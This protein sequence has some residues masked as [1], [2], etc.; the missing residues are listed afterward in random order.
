M[1]IIAAFDI[2][3]RRIGVAFSDPFASYAMP[4]ETYFRTGNFRED[5]EQIV[6]IAKERGATVIVCGLPLNADGTESV[7]S[8]KTRRFAAALEE[9]AGVPVVLEDER[10]TTREARGDL[11]LLGISTKKDKKK[12]SVDSLAAA[13]IL[14][15]YLAKRSVNMKEENSNYEAEDNIVEL[16][17][18]EGNTYSYEHLMTF[19]FKGE[20]YVALAQVQ[21]EDY[22]EEEG[23]EVAIFHLVGEEN[24]EQLETIEDENLL[25]AVF[26]EFCAQYEDEGE[27][28]E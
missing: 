4:S 7:Q 22:D 1:E 20:W 23:D 2:G 8:E 27:E 28:E 13:Y 21:A 19:E 16:T 11:N 17:D 26:A 6:A 25:S 10:F 18:E 3:D 15:S 9:R 14:E 12:K 5:V 24:D